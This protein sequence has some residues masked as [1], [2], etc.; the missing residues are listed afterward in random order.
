MPDGF[1][2]FVIHNVKVSYD[3]LVIWF[4][5]YVSVCSGKLNS[6]TLNFLN[7][8]ILIAQTNG[9]SLPVKYNNFTSIVY[10]S[11]QPTKFASFSAKFHQLL[12]LLH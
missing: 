10:K 9:C 8:L 7:F 3:Y 6:Q 5:I 11:Q 2:K 4:Y 1:K 12:S